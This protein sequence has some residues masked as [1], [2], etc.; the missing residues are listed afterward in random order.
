VFAAV[1]IIVVQIVA[2][3]LRW[4]A[5]LA[6]I[7]ASIAAARAVGLFYIS[8]FFNS[9]A[10]SLGG[11]VARTLLANRAEA[12][13]KAVVTSVIVDRVATIAALALLVL[14]T[15]PMFIQRAGYAAALVPAAVAA[16]SIAGIVLVAQ[17]HRF[18]LAWQR[19]QLLRGLRTLLEAMRGIFLAPAAAF[20][21][22]AWAVLAQASLALSAYVIARGLDIP[23]ALLDCMVLMQPVA[24]AVALPISIGGWGVREAA[25]V[26][27]FGLVGLEPSSALAIS[28]QLGLLSLVATLPGGVLFL[29]LRGPA[30]AMGA[31]VN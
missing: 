18:P 7:G 19:H 31:T 14:L 13:L 22:I 21:V 6:R 20:R 23:L 24:L 28:V 12:N 25:M 1:L 10:G 4:H 15:L 2:G 26:G 27:A 9:F 3:G 8:V 16:A 17:L 30:S 11:D 29:L 5:I